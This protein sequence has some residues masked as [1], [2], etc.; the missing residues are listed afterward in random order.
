MSL[1][2]GKWVFVGTWQAQECPSAC[3]WLFSQ[4][5]RYL[6]DLY[7]QPLLHQ[8]ICRYQ[9]NTIIIDTDLKSRLQHVPALS[10]YGSTAVIFLGTGRHAM[11]QFSLMSIEELRSRG[12]DELARLLK[13]GEPEKLRLTAEHS[14]TM[15]DVNRKLQAHVG[16]IRGLQEANQR[17]QGENEELQDLCCFL[18]TSRQNDQRVVQE[19]QKFGRYTSDVMSSDVR[20]FQKKL[21]VLEARLDAL[22]KENIELKELC[23]LLADDRATQE[24]GQIRDMGDGSSSDSPSNDKLPVPGPINRNGS[25]DEISPALNGKANSV[26]DLC[27]YDMLLMHRVSFNVSLRGTLYI[28]F[29]SV[30]LLCLCGVGCATSALSVAR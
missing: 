9:T 13:S 14:R 15:K 16:E 28:E 21:G 25:A 27:M 1:R 30:Y 6:Q 22:T 17:L 18:D 4:S 2:W 12:S 8:D 19:W 24:P 7:N 20:T 11:A 23:L 5:L 3:S 10:R 26:C 29:T